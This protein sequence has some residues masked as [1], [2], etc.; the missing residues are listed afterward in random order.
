LDRDRVGV[1][2]NFFDIGGHSL[3]LAAVHARLTAAT[4]RSIPML[5]LFRH[6]TVRALAAHL[7]GAADRPELARAALRAAARRSRARRIPPRRP[8]GN[9]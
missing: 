8:G 7:D 3:A 9:A 2:D 1:T 6:P 5:D 4:G